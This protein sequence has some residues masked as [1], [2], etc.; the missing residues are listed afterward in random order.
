MKGA[1]IYSYL[2]ETEAKSSD[3]ISNYHDLCFQPSSPQNGSLIPSIGPTIVYLRLAF[4]MNMV[5]SVLKIV[6][7]TSTLISKQTRL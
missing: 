5:H 7:V 2:S 4:F 6:E 1:T 3:L